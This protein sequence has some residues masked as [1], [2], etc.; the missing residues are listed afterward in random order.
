MIW[1]QLCPA[2]S[3][4]WSPLTEATPAALLLAPAPNT[5]GYFP[6]KWL[7]NEYN[8]LYRKGKRAGFKECVRVPWTC[9]G[10][11]DS[12]PFAPMHMATERSRVE[13]CH[14]FKWSS[15]SLKTPYLINSHTLNYLLLNCSVVTAFKKNFWFCF[16]VMK[17]R[18]LP[19][20]CQSLYMTGTALLDTIPLTHHQSM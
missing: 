19:S 14:R 1:T 16:Y 12:G 7:C 5:Y 2:W 9:D 10:R 17:Y 13:H 18:L 15:I 11:V 20:S 4:P 3:S 6:S 8:D